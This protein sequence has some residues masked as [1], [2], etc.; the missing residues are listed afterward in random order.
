MVGFPICPP[1]SP[2][3][4]I[5]SRT[6]M[7]SAALGAPSPAGKNEISLRCVGTEP[8]ISTPVVTLPQTSPQATPPVSSLGSAHSTQQPFWPSRPRTL[9]AGSTPYVKWTLA[10]SEGKLTCLR[11]CLNY[12]EI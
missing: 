12:R 9:E 1:H 6:Q 4:Y 11:N 7:P 3:Q 2:L 5:T 10:S 8:V